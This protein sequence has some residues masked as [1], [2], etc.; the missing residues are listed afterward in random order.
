MR[1]GVLNWPALR[2]RSSDEQSVPPVCF[3]RT[4]CGSRPLGASLPGIV[5]TATI[6]DQEVVREAAPSEELMQAFYYMHSVPSREF[7]LAVVEAGPFSLTPELPEGGVLKI[8]ARGRAEVPVKATFKEGVQ[9]GAITLKADA[10]P[11]GFRIQAPA[12]PAGKTE[13]TVVITTI[14]QQVRVGQT[15][16]LIITGTMKADK[17]TISGFVPAI[18]FEII[19]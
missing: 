14:G 1:A 5:G 8:K 6:G 17:E 11:K 18:P 19:R 7:F 16:V 13:T 15:G 9:P 4:C 3:G 12:I 2:R 10:P